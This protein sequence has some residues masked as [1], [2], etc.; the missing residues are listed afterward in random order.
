[1]AEEVSKVIKCVECDGD[2]GEGLNAALD[3]SLNC[4][5]CGSTGRKIEIV[6][7]ERLEMH[8][9]IG[10]KARHGDSGRVFLESK[11]GDDLHRKTGQWNHLERVINRKD[12][13]YK[14]VISNPRTGEVI[15]QCE[16]PL[17]QHF[18]HGSAKRKVVDAGEE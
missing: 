14:E 7:A 11:F 3:E 15:H 5:S 8:S 1:M 2:L 10:I 18:G 13:Q 12:D 4:P 16:E 17:S 6:I 9:Q